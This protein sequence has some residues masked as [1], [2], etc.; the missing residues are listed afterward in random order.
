MNFN[1][2]TIKSQEAIQKAV[3][4]AKGAGNQAIEPVHLLKGILTEG[5]SLLTFIFQK[6]GA[7]ASQVA[8]SIDR[9]IESEPKVSGGEPYLSRTSNDVLQKALDVAKKQGDQ[10]VTIEAILLG[11]FLVKSS[12]SQILK[13]AGLTEHELTAAI[14]ELRKGKKA[15]DQSAEDTYNALSK[16]AINLNER[17]RSGKLDPVIGR[18]DEIRRVLQI[19]SRRTKN[20][21]MLI[22]EPG[23]GKTAIAE[24]LAHRIVRGDVPENL[25]DKQIYSLDMGA[26]V[27]GAKY[28]GEFE[29]RLKAIVNEVTQADGDIILFIDEI[30]TLVGAGK[31][32]GAMDAANILKPALARG[33][34]RS[35][36]A[37]TLDEY[38]KYFEKD[39][40]L[41]RRF[42]KVMVNEPDELSAI[43][44][45]RGLKER[46][47]NH[48]QV[49]IRDEAIIA[50]VQLSERYI[51]DR[52]LP[53]KAI[54]LIDEAASKLR[55]ERDSV[56]QA[57]DEI[58][59]K[60]AQLEIEREAIKREGDK[61]K[62]KTLEKEL[63]D[64]RDTEKEFKAKWQSQKELINRIQQNKIDIEQLKFEA[65]RA[66]REGDYAKVAEIRYSKI[67]Q[68]EKE[69][70]DVQEQLKAMQ[71]EKSLIKE[72]VDAD[73]I[74]D[75]VSRWTGIPVTKMAR[76]E[77]EKLLHLEEELHRRVV[78][79]NEAIAA[80]ADAVRRSRAGLNDPRR[81]IGSFIFLGTTG[82]G[83]T[84]LAKALAEYLFDDENM[85]TRIDMSEYQEKHT[86]SRLVG[87]PP[88]YVGYD[89]GGQLTE[90]V[91]RKPY[92]VVLFDEI[93]KAHPDVF[94]ILL[95]V[96]DD[97][98]LTDNKGRL[99]NFKNTIIIMTSNMGSNVIRE[100]FASINDE[101][102]DEVVEK[103]KEQVLE[104][105]KS[106][107]RPEFLNRIDE[108]IMFTPLNEREIQDIVGIQVN[109]IKKMLAT[110][111]VNLEVTPSALSYLAK[112]GYNPEFGAR[113]VKRVLQRM[114][115]NRLSKDILAQKVDRE[116][117]IIIDAKDDELIFRN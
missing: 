22:G 35:I 68:K 24:G 64:L 51:T 86:V 26:L 48:H 113:P 40:A 4:I 115:L 47:E 1:N 7:N 27:A 16:Y 105:L 2:F 90:A 75:V 39:K 43:S 97:G 69:N 42:Q 76:S 49:R 52:F 18:D 93:E 29:E 112:E 11:I 111:G 104:M 38:Q 74:A 101:N 79:Q 12:A 23:T 19:L 65:D 63:A 60:I 44:I 36:G 41:E 31:G 33:E 71:G 20:N 17:A 37:T 78:G 110:N 85:M 106:T 80:I 6:V 62:V 83:K 15:T 59:R 81:P 88:G 92:S 53:D 13:D 102:H 66:E 91:R 95:Q 99:V 89:E 56:P 103:T 5:D 116:H 108:I 54:D 109:S 70:A 98:R 57:L 34:L 55:L 77:Q 96:L 67:Q 28:K 30:H 58:T 14:E 84:E 46:Y 117:P 32:E 21:P 61:E 82:V 10:Y 100:N 3:E 73:D 94:N 50:A 107:I 45:L 114:V 25:K 8:G 9:A 72:E 87:A